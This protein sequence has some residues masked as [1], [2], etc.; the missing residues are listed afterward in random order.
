MKDLLLK[1]NKGVNKI[2]KIDNKCASETNEEVEK[3]KQKI[4]SKYSEKKKN[5]IEE[6]AKLN[7]EYG[8][9]LFKHIENK[10]AISLIKVV[11]DK[12]Y[13][14]YEFSGNLSEM[15]KTRENSNSSWT[16]SSIED[17]RRTTRSN[18]IISIINTAL[19]YGFLTHSDT[20]DEQ[21]GNSNYMP[22][23]FGK[24]EFDYSCKDE[25]GYN[26]SYWVSVE[27]IDN[28]IMVEYTNDYE[29]EDCGEEEIGELTA[30]IYFK[31]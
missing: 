10:K 4:Y 12:T 21:I 26:D 15:V 22:T 3:L 8:K 6:M 28:G 13:D 25:D 31:I 1:I 7:I 9:K 19:N 5:I 2:N 29:E 17:I 24:I 16:Y 23:E 27:L 20:D 14:L 18:E 11:V 30:R